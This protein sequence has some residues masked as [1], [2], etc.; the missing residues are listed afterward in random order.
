MVIPVG[1]NGRDEH[2]GQAILHSTKDLLIFAKEQAQQIQ[3]ANGRYCSLSSRHQGIG[4]IGSGG[5]LRGAKEFR[6]KALI[7]SNTAT[8]DLLSSNER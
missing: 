5:N 4:Q 1:C 8:K 3:L 7:A 6:F 2:V